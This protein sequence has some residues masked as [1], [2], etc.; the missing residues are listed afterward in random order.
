MPLLKYP[1]GFLQTDACTDTGKRIYHHPREQVHPR[2]ETVCKQGQMLGVGAVVH[3]G[4]GVQGGGAI[5]LRFDP[6]GEHPGGGNGQVCIL[7]YESVHGH[8][9]RVVAVVQRWAGCVG[10]HCGVVLPKHS[11]MEVRPLRVLPRGHRHWRAKMPSGHKR[12][13]QIASW[14]YCNRRRNSVHPGFLRCRTDDIVPG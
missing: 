14:I 8:V 12:D 10:H 4:Y 9:R 1:R 5:L 13:I 7:D 11:D 2:P 3:V 6:V